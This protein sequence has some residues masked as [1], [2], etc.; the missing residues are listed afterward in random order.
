ME[1]KAIF[2]I[3]ISLILFK[4][5]SGLTKDFFL[6]DHERNTIVNLNDDL[7]GENIKEIGLIKNP[8]LIM[9]TGIS[10]KYLAVYN[11]S[12]I[13][14]VKGHTIFQPGSL[15]VFNAKPG[16]TGD[17]LEIGFPPY[18]WTYTKDRSHFFIAYYTSPQKEQMEIL[19]YD[20]SEAK[21][22]KVD[23]IKGEILDLKLTYDE[24]A[25]LMIVNSVNHQELVAFQIGSFQPTS[26]LSIGF[27]AQQMFILGPDR[28]ALVGFNHQGRKTGSGII[29]IIDTYG[30]AVV[31]ERKLT[32]PN[33]GVYW[34]EKNRSLFVTNGILTGKLMKGRIYK[35]TGA[36][37]IRQH[38][39]ARPWAGFS[40]LPQKDQV[41]I[42]NQ[43]G[44][45][46]IDYAQNF[47]KTYNL[48]GS[49][50]YP[51]R[52]HYYFQ[53]LP[54]ANLAIIVCFEK[55][56]LI[57]YDLEKNQVLKNAR[58]GRTGERILNLLTFKGDMQSRT[59]A[60]TNHD[61]TRFYVLNCATRDITVYDQ[62]FNIL[63]YLIPDEPPLAMFQVGQP[64]METLVV[65]AMGLY[66]ID[67]E[68][69]TLIR[70]AEF[71][72]VITQVK[73][74]EADR[75]SVVLYTDRL[76][77]VLKPENFEVKHQFYLYGDPEE[78]F[79]KL[80]NHERRYYFIP[81]L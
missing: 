23:G 14:N 78:K 12:R 60:T 34:Y 49:N 3:I 63:K 37:G 20:V 28:A 21:S 41:Y 11:S 16:K 35:V 39:V 30:S 29:K 32:L 77:L 44:L 4:P 58:S 52:Y 27:K 36:D 55:G 53:C 18:H 13:K 68:E 76:L 69:L 72:T 48:S 54:S 6:Y 17:L 65:T 45:T 47:S 42:Q 57:F 73:Y 43:T 67:E 59:A 80:K 70:V 8:D 62:G 40:Y 26:R 51:G 10:D 71:S 56:Y 74:F 33:S 79:R 31:E 24:K 15:I 22:V 5:A 50:Y 46:L 19:H 75:H 2:F 7:Q 61:Q 1:R 25:L 38:Q 81:E 66:K 64:A 9:A